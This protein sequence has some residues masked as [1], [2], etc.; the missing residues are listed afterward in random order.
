MEKILRNKY[1]H[2]Y[3]KIIGI[4]IILCS[5]ALL[6]INVIYGNVLN[7]KWLNKKLGS[8]GEYGAILAASL[9]IL[10]Q[11]WLFFKK[12]NTLGF[13]LIKEL[14]LFIKNFHVL[15]G[16]AVIAVSITHGVYFFIKGSRHILIIYSGIFSL[17]TLIIL[18]IIGFLLQRHNKKINL[19]LYRKAHQIIAIIFGIGL[20]IHLIV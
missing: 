7:A 5:A 14:Y 9:W 15:I 11:L 19:I 1:F 3:V 6:V 13:K 20:F 2:M 16:Y 8:F 18:G 17:L 10:R 12:K 4:I